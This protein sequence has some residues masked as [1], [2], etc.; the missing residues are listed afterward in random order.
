M[1]QEYDAMNN[2]F[3][4]VFTHTFTNAVNNGYANIVSTTLPQSKTRKRCC[5]L[6]SSALSLQTTFLI[7]G[8]YAVRN[9]M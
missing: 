4:N 1:D 3:P 6:S 7:N 8:K 5:V 2:A 9:A